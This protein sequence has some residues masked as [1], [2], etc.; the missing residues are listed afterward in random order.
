MQR[1]EE[2]TIYQYTLSE[3]IGQAQ[4]GSPT[5]R[6][7]SD[8]AGACGSFSKSLSE[9]PDPRGKTFVSG[10]LTRLWMQNSFLKGVR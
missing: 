7:M 3:R 9:K 8:A 6:F 2:L 5:M 10:Q 4:E 1:P